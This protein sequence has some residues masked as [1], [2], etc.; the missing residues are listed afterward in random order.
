MRFLIGAL[1][2]QKMDD[3]RGRCRRT[4]FAEAARFGHDAMFLIGGAQSLERRGDELHMP[5][6]DTYPELPQKTKWLCRWAITQPGWDYI[7]KCDDDTLV[8]MDR[9][10]RVDLAGVDYLGRSLGNYASGGAGYF[11]SRKA[12]GI[13][14]E[15]LTALTGSEDLLVGQVLRENGIILKDDSRFV[16]WTK[17]DQPPTR[18]NDRVTGHAFSGEEFE[19]AWAGTRL[20]PIRIVMPTSNRYVKA[21]AASLTLL[22][23]YWPSHPPVDVL[24][25]E[26]APEAQNGEMRFGMG[27]QAEVSWTQALARYL[28]EVNHDDL[29]VLM[30]DDYGLSRQVDAG[31]FYVAM[32]WMLANPTAACLHLTWQPPDPKKP[33]PDARIEELPAWQYSVNTQAAIWRRSVLLDVCQNHLKATAEAF[34]LDGSRWFNSQRYPAWKTYQWAM[35]RP[36]NASGF[37]DSVD[38]G[39]WVLPYN[40]LMRRGTPDPRHAG[41]CEAER[42]TLA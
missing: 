42:I 29:V 23:R 19:A 12:A 21:A 14:A 4:W 16:P 30:L 41:F 1:S 11:L 39:E 32:D 2:G 10:S 3:R 8:I 36:E 33:T 35:K 38:K 31:K 28:L 25:F 9:L 24:H 5:C 37:V 27:K 18:F 15:K 17:K 20:H 13:V 22:R 34:E 6:P 26:T 7:F 40:N